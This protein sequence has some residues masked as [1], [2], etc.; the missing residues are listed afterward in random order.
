MLKY[1]IGKSEQVLHISNDVLKHFEMFKQNK[2]R[3]KEAGG[4]LFVQRH[5]NDLHLELAT[6]PRL[7]DKRFRTHYIPDMVASQEEIKEQYKNGLHFIGNWHTH[8]ENKPSP[9]KVDIETMKE[10]FLTAKQELLKGFILIIIGRNNF[11]DGLHLSVHDGEDWF[12]L[13]N[14]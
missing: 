12:V 9:S 1:P 13:Q 3:S 8:P 2:I 11:P 5:K 14:V 4:Q 7:T 6:G 10:C